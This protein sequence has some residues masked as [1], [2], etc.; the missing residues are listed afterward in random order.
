MKFKYM[1]GYLKGCWP[2]VFNFCR[3]CHQGPVWRLEHKELVV[4]VS[5]K[6]SEIEKVKAMNH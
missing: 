1:K 5:A 4:H 6:S 3:G 2:A